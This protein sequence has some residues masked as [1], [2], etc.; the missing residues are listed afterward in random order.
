M[1]ASSLIMNKAAYGLA[2]L[3]MCG[4]QLRRLA[5]LLCMADCIAGVGLLKDEEGLL[6]FSFF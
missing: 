5:C 3:S 1:A 4:V 6:L 2:A